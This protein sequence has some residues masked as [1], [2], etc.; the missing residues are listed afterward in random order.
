M[1]LYGFEVRVIFLVQGD[2]ILAFAWHYNRKK[3]LTQLHRIMEYHN[4]NGEIV[5]SKELEKLLAERISEV[6]EGG[7]IFK[8][9]DFDYKNRAVYENIIKIPRGKT[10][11]YSKIAKL[12]GVNFTEMLITLMRN[13]LQVLIPCHRLVTKKGTLFGFHPLGK[14]VKKKLLQVEG[15]M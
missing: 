14:D 10:A 2:D 6:V 12:S 8:L 11:T 15:V 5:E 3:A 13:P 7:K 1:D 4:L 9:P